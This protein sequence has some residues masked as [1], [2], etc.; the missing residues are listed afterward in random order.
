MGTNDYNQN[1]S[2]GLP[3]EGIKGSNF[4]KLTEDTFG[5]QY[6]DLMLE[7][8]ID[9]PR[10]D[11]YLMMPFCAGDKYL[12][13]SGGT[14]AREYYDII[15]GMADLY[16][17][18]VIPNHKIVKSNKN[19]GYIYTDDSNFHYTKDGMEKLADGIYRYITSC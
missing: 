12:K 7:L 10:T 11:I 3:T 8:N 6:E 16:L 17:F 5:F 4:D 14:F 9:Y 2:S 13:N 19:I 18:R 1:L 15:E